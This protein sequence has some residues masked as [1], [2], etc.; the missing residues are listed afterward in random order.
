MSFHPKAGSSRNYMIVVRGQRPSASSCTSRGLLLPQ[1]SEQESWTCPSLS[2][3]AYLIGL[4]HN[5]CGQGNGYVDWFIPIRMHIWS[6]GWAHFWEGHRLCG[7]QVDTSR[8][9]GERDKDTS[10]KTGCSLH[11]MD[12]WS[13]RQQ[14]TQGYV[15]WK[16]PL[17]L[18]IRKWFPDYK[19]T[20]ATTTFQGQYVYYFVFDLRWLNDFIFSYKHYINSHAKTQDCICLISIG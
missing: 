6:W 18:P 15:Y 17:V 2:G 12:I 5:N 10:R 8:K 14:Q 20:T 11:Y 7:G 3:T 13:E 16:S 19:R 9:T 4:I 1:H